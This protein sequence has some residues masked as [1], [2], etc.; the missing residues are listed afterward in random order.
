MTRPWFWS[1]RARRLT[2]SLAPQSAASTLGDLLED[3]PLPRDYRKLPWCKVQRPIWP[4][5]LEAEPG[6]II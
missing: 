2:R 3:G 5:D 4:L 6:L 1:S